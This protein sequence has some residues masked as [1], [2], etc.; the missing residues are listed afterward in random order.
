[1]DSLISKEDLKPLLD[2]IGVE[3][4]QM[5]KNR[6]LKQTEVEGGKFPALK[7]ATIKNKLRQKGGIASNAYKRMIETGDFNR[8]A[9]EYKTGDDN[10]T[11]SISKE[12]HIGNGKSKSH[13]YLDL[14]GWQMRGKFEKN[15]SHYNAGADFFGISKK[16]GEELMG[17]YKKSFADLFM[18]KVDEYINKVV[19]NAS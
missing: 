17:K 3:V 2:L 19:K 14:A 10:V 15:R 9:F 12:S 18:K 5:Q 1:M 8:N 11:I 13:T 6:I 4:C 16:E 7:P